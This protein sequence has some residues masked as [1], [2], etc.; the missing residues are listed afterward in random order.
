M[1]K[2]AFK[3]VFMLLAFGVVVYGCIVTRNLVLEVMTF[4]L[5]LYSLS[6]YAFLSSAQNSP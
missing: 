3:V 1:V 6:P 4:L 2:R 5:L